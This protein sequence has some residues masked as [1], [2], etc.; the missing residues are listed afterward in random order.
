[1]SALQT[2]TFVMALCFLAIAAM[3]FAADRAL[4]RW[5]NDEPRFGQPDDE[6]DA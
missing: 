4:K 3:W 6:D 1:M 2:G 5:S